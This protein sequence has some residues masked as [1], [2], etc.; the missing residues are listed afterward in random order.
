MVPFTKTGNIG[1]GSGQG[2][3]HSGR[4]RK[5]ITTLSLRFLET[6]NVVNQ[7][8]GYKDMELG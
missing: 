3:E 6:S 5:R 1:G 4:F 7:A 8:D 2:G